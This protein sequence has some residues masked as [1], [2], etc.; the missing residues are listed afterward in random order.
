M[1]NPSEKDI[2][3]FCSFADPIYALIV[4]NGRDSSIL[5]NVREALPL[6]LMSGG[7]NVS[8]AEV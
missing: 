6:K 2:T 7:I 5:E 4:T 8:R 3:D 1:P